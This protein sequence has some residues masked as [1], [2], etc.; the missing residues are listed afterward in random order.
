MTSN[1]RKGDA[2]N[3]AVSNVDDRHA[4]RMHAHAPEITLT[5]IRS[6]PS[7][8][9]PREEARSRELRRRLPVFLQANGIG[10]F[11]ELHGKDARTC[12]STL[13]SCCG[14]TSATDECDF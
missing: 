2:Q 14:R 8:A 13:K 3:E 12:V 10:A 11:P 6:Q 5:S 4:R 1:F 9:P 7:G